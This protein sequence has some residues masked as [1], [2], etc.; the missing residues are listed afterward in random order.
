MQQE[1]PLEQGLSRQSTEHRVSQSPR[2]KL[3]AEM[4]INK[5]SLL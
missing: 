2:E 3:R 4:G 1:V 5:S